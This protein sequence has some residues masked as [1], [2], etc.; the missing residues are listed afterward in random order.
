LTSRSTASGRT[1]EKGLNITCVR[2]RGTKPTIE[3]VIQLDFEESARIT[4]M[5]EGSCDPSGLTYLHWLKAE[6]ERARDDHP[7]GTSLDPR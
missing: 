1:A 7:T 5:T 3:S 4:E 2:K 6:V